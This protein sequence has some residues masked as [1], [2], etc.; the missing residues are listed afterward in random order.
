MLQDTC[1]FTTEVTEQV[2]KQTK[3]IIINNGNQL[4]AIDAAEKM[5]EY[6]FNGDADR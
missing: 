4:C 1:T 2:L 5:L 3:A 6:S